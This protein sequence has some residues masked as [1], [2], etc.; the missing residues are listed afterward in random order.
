MSSDTLPPIDSTHQ[1]VEHQSEE[2][3]DVPIIFEA[4][5]PEAWDD[6]PVTFDAL[7]EGQGAGTPG[8]GPEVAPGVGDGGAPGAEPEEVASV[9]Q[10]SSGLVN[11]LMSDTLLKCST[12]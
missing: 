6:V 7:S 8:D 1:T 5:E 9:T 4:F 10:V 3:A 12:G 11:D 2:W